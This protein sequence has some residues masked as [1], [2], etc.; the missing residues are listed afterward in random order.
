MFSV[1][2]N[3]CQGRAL[4]P[5]ETNR[6][7]KPWGGRRADPVRS[8]LGFHHKR[9]RFLPTMPARS[10]RQPPGQCDSISCRIIPPESEPSRRDYCD[11]SDPH[12]G[13]RRPTPAMSIEKGVARRTRHKKV[14]SL[15]SLPPPPDR[16]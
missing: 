13:E 9:V 12:R 16:R 10:R 5:P 14:G 8:P 3:T 6:E 11:G 2:E 7:A 15:P 1:S 4:D